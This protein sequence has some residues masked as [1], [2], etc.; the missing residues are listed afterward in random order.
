MK[1]YC[2]LIFTCTTLLYSEENTDFD[3]AIQIQQQI[4]HTIHKCL[5]AYVSI[6]G[7]AGA[8]I[9]SDGYIITNNHVVE[10]VDKWSVIT[11]SKKAYRA[12]VVG[13]DVLG[14]ICLLKISGQPKNL[15]F[16]K[17]GDSDL[18]YHG[19]RVLAMGNPFLYSKDGS[20]S[21]SLGVVSALHCYQDNYGDAIQTDTSL[22]PGNSG[23][24]LVNLQGELVGVCGRIASRFNNRR[25]SGVGFAITSKQVKNFLPLLKRGEKIIHGKIDVEAR[26]YFNQGV[27]IKSSLIKAL[28]S[29]DIVLK[30]ANIPIY[31]LDLFYGKLWTYP[32]NASVIITVK[33]QDKVVTTKV[34]LKSKEDE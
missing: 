3:I 33:R 5:D 24:P 11:G 21:V 25:S 15:P 23:G 32:A 12:F 6:G 31:S 30:I 4:K 1:I 13:R 27:L 16:L 19:Q 17:L 9:S 7:G 20:P 2:L 18:L 29:G 26:E 10:D 22:N 14:D 8:I 28:R 34:V